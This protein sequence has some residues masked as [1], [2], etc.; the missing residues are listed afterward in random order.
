[1]GSRGFWACRPA[2]TPGRQ[3]SLADSNTVFSDFGVQG[4]HRNLQ[5]AGSFVLIVAILQQVGRYHILLGLLKCAQP[6]F[7]LSSQQI[8]LRIL[9]NIRR[10]ILGHDLFGGVF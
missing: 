2:R 9:R 3:S 10:I 7:G 6:D 8:R 4:V 5:H 1:M